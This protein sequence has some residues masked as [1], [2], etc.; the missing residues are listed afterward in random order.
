[1]MLSASRLTVLDLF[2]AGSRAAFHVMVSGRYGG[3]LEGVE[4]GG[5]RDAELYVAG[6]ATVDN[7]RVV[8]RAVTDRLAAQRRLRTRCATVK[9]Q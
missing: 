3:G 4:V 6:I 8:V 1:M 7:G 9:G 5:D 2:T